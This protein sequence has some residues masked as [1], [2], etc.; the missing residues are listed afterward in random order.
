MN[1]ESKINEYLDK[2]GNDKLLMETQ[3]AHM[4]TVIKENEDMDYNTLVNLLSNFNTINIKYEQLC[5]DLTLFISLFKPKEE[6]EIRIYKTEELID[7]FEKEIS[8]ID[9]SQ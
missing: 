5:N 3:F 6:Q 7:L 9:N 8:K 4:E 2:I 1:C